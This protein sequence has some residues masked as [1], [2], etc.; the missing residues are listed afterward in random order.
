MI[1]KFYVVKIVIRNHKIR[2]SCSEGNLGG[3]NEGSL[4]V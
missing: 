2:I 3:D 4:V 1:A